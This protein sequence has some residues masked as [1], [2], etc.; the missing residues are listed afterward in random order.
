[1]NKVTAFEKYI[2]PILT[3]KEH[4]NTR[5]NIDLCSKVLQVVFGAGALFSTIKAINHLGMILIGGSFVF[6]GFLL[7]ISACEAIGCHDIFRV[8]NNV[9]TVFKSGVFTRAAHAYLGNMPGIIDALSKPSE[10]PAEIIHSCEKHLGN[11]SGFTSAL[12]KDTLTLPHFH[13]AIVGILNNPA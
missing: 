9:S 11:A 8:A 12:T 6:H 1:M 3:N 13:D 7:T 5:E 2:Q 10:D 4:Q